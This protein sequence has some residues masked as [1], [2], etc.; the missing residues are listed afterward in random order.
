MVKSDILHVKGIDVGIYTENYRNEYISRI[1]EKYVENFSTF[2]FAGRGNNLTF[3][4]DLGRI[5]TKLSIQQNN[6]N[7][8]ELMCYEEGAANPRETAEVN[9]ITGNDNV[10]LGNYGR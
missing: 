8:S 2:Y 1:V 5:T 10:N 4:K 6:Q 9:E 3:A 7:M